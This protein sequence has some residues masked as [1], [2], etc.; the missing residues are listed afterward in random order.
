MAEPGTPRRRVALIAPLAPYRGGIARHST[1]LARALEA[2]GDLRLDAVSFS[3]LYPR[4]LYPGAD[5]IDPGAALPAVPRRRD[6]LDTLAPWNW[7]R[8]ADEIA[9][10]APELAVM[11]AWTFFVAPC[12]GAVAAGLRRRGVPVTMVVHNAEDHEG[13]GW[14]RALM[15]RQLARAS[16]IVTHNEA[17]AGS[18]AA[19]GL[20]A[21]VTLRP[22][23]VYD[24][25]PA[26]EGALPREAPLELLFFGLVRPYKGLEILLDALAEAPAD[27][28]RLSVVGEH[29]GGL[30]ETRAQIARLALSDRVRLVPRYVSDQEAA[31]HFA[32]ADALVT[33]YRSAS[34]SGV[35]AMA[36]HYRLPV[37]ASDLPGLAEAVR[38]RETGWLFP[39]GDRAAL[40][41]LIAGPVTR[42]AAA[43]MAPAIDAA[44]AERS[45]AAFA[46]AVLATIP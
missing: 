42:D 35:I 17:I 15:R 14:K 41:R 3:R 45:W 10:E 30:D 2:R 24:D 38:D 37:I 22:H 28:V 7:R 18:L 39:V 34:A 26:P 43:A 13:A 11:P 44:R 5:Q 1:A 23:P 6:V 20:T 29:W 8:L 21:P 36:Q 27:T 12:L 9:A 25:F 16:A 33:P 31:E 32:R 4:L 19:L 46:D 40:A